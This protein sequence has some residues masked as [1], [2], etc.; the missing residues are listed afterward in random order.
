MFWGG[1]IKMHISLGWIP[2]LYC[3]EQYF[4]YG[5]VCTFNK[6]FRKKNQVDVVIEDEDSIYLLEI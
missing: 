4:M 6:S 1:I 5:S 3:N 2:I